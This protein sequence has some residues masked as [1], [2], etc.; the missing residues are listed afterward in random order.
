MVN[1]AEQRARLEN[2]LT[3]AIS[4]ILRLEKLLSGSFAHKAP[5][6]VVA[7]E[8][9]KL[10]SFKKTTTKLEAQIAELS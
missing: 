1:P 2:E 8:R 7:A 5:E 6:Q 3:A 4:Q 9:K 10:T